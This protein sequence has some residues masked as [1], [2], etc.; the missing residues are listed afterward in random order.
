MTIHTACGVQFVDPDSGACRP[1]KGSP[2]PSVVPSRG[3]GSTGGGDSCDAGAAGLDD[4]LDLNDVPDLSRVRSGTAGGVP[5]AADLMAARSSASF[6]EGIRNTAERLQAMVDSAAPGDDGAS[7]LQQ[8]LMPEAAASTASSDILYSSGVGP[9]AIPS[10]LALAYGSTGGGVPAAGGTA[11]GGL[12][13]S[14]SS[15]MAGGISAARIRAAY[16]SSS[17]GPQAFTGSSP[18]AGGTGATS[19]RLLSAAEALRP[20]QARAHSQAAPAAVAVVAGPVARA[21]SGVLPGAATRLS[22]T[23]LPSTRSEVLRPTSSRTDCTLQ[24]N[25]TASSITAGLATAPSSSLCSAAA[26]AVDPRVGAAPGPQ[27]AMSA[28]QLVDHLREL[29]AAMIAGEPR[30]G[31]QATDPRVGADAGADVELEDALLAD[32]LEEMLWGRL[33]HKDGEATSCLLALDPSAPANAPLA[34]MINEMRSWVY[35]NMW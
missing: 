34:G 35:T 4:W 18:R 26:S 7:F 27:A 31:A 2:T 1:A 10:I 33:R 24:R 30:V 22:S 16:G 19:P 20:P 11:G 14:A 6:T 21:A 29:H 17:S 28:S 15:P 23:T 3:A 13:A 8:L 25:D 5:A 12:S 32:E 9:T